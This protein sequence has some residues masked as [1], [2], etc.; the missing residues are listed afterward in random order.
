MGMARIAPELAAL[1]AGL[2]AEE[3]PVISSLL[4]LLEE[5]GELPE[6]PSLQPFLTFVDV[7]G[8][9]V[10]VTQLG[11]LRSE[12]VKHF[13]EVSG[14]TEFWPL[15]TS[16][17]MNTAPVAKIH[18]FARAL[19]LVE[20]RDRELR[21]TYVGRQLGQDQR[22]WLEHIA[23]V[24]P[25]RPDEFERQAGWL[26]L[27][28]VASG[29]EPAEWRECVADTLTEI[30][31]GIDIDGELVP[32]DSWNHTL[33]LLDLLTKGFGNEFVSDSLGILSEQDILRNHAAVAAL[34]RRAVLPR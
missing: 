15:P 24:L 5:Q 33:S 14:A 2:S 12:T 26:T 31:W 3:A 21:V 13:A 11:R 16:S 4:E 1:T 28:V 6:L 25:F 17:E 10:K 9:G 32:P 30:G 27:L 34:A 29:L 8:T 22:A 19:R 7:I 20:I 18:W 23:A